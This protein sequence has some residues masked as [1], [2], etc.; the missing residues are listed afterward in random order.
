[1]N[2]R[3]K[4]SPADLDRAVREAERS[5]YA[6]YGLEPQEKMVTLDVGFGR[7]EVRLTVFGTPGGQEPPIVLLHGIASVTVLFAP[8]LAHLRDRYVIAVDWPGHGLS[9]ESA[10]PAGFSIRRH[11][12]VT[13]ESLLDLLDL[14]EVDLVGHSMGAQFGLYAA[15]D[16]DD[17]V[18]R[19]VL[20]GAPGA[21]FQGVEPVLAMKL[22]AVPGLGRLMLSLPMS[23]KAFERNNE[24]TLGPG[25]LKDLPP[26]L[27]L[28]ARLLGSRAVNARSIAAYFRALI[29]RSS[30]RTGVAVPIEELSRLRQ[31]TLLAWGDED[32]FLAPLDGARSVVAIRDAHLI[33]VPHAGHAPWLTAT[34]L[35]GRAV[36]AHLRTQPALP[37]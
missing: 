27:V 31:P 14:P 20:L 29:K 12:T 6:H 28:A 33:R 13:I 24:L 19:L 10:L 25:A 30:V 26:D 35:V 2:R 34:G 4:L 8:L 22:L 23:D 11:A 3:D 1:M 36:V 32:V 21:G 9:A 7:A 18:R 5:A 16:L 37:A 17:R 15:L